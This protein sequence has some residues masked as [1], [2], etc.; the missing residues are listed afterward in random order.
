MSTSLHKVP[1][2]TNSVFDYTKKILRGKILTYPMRGVPILQ[3][4][5]TTSTR[6]TNISICFVT[7]RC[8]LNLYNDSDPEVILRLCS[9]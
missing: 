5:P 1:V 2:T 4:F 9:I 6:N 8:M 3:R 7:S